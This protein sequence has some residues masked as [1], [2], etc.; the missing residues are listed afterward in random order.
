M[1]SGKNRKET[2]QF[3][4]NVPKELVAWAWS[5]EQRSLNTSQWLKWAADL[6]LPP[7][8]DTKKR[9]QDVVQ[10]LDS[11]SKRKGEKTTKYKTSKNKTKKI[12]NNSKPIS[13]IKKLKNKQSK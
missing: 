12:I 8:L 5:P 3:H 1:S 7:T 11:R 13:K 6:G 2:E 9:M 4:P 10:S